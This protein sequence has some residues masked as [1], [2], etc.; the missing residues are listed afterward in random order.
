MVWGLK[1]GGYSIF[2]RKILPK[3]FVAWHGV[4]S[5]TPQTTFI[6]P[7][8]TKSLFQSPV[9]YLNLTSAEDPASDP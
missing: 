6:H 5:P 1:M 8:I 7:A 2:M 4:E 3:R 9:P